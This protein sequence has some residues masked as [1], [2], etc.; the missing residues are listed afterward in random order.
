M[1]KTIIIAEA[2][3]NHNGD[4]KTAKKLIDVAADAGVDYVKFQTFKADRVVSPSAKKAKYQFDNDSSKD[5]SQLNMLK[6]LELSDADHKE[7]ISYC[8]SKNI[9]FFST[10]F[11]E[12]GEMICVMEDIGRH[13]AVDKVIGKL[14]LKKQL[15]RAFAIT[16][17]GRISY[18]IVM[19]AFR[20]KIP[21]LAAV[22]APSSLAVDYSK[23]L[24]ITLFGFCR[25]ENATCY[26]NM[27]RVN[28]IDQTK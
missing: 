8:K 13:N 23:E 1:N 6:K 14:L 24:G 3:V 15:N 22:S 26:S 5:D 25:G 18:E 2:G 28:A 20:A 21:V 27:Q 4:I 11:D 17:S 16:V 10:A 12:K 19:K 9:S 7:L